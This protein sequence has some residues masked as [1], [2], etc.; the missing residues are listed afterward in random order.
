MMNRLRRV[1]WATALVSVA[2]GLMLSMQFKVQRQVALADLAAVQRT[3]ELV[4]QLAEAEKHRDELAA[5]VELLRQQ[6]LIS[7]KT[8]NEFQALA[9]QLEQAQLQAGLLPLVGPGVT[10]TMAD[11][12][13]PVTPGENP[14]NFIIHDEDVLRVI[15]ELRAAGAEAIAINGQRVTGRT[16]IR[17]TGPVV[18]ING[19]RTAPP[20]T[21][22]AIGNP[23][24]LERAIMMKGG[25]AESLKFWG[26]QVT[27]KKETSVRVPAYTA[28][29]RLEYAQPA[30]EVEEVAP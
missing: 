1:P 4:A 11:S 3:E 28:R 27:V 26:I 6:Q 7:V 18:T 22:V 5:E 14:N 13:L 20:L 29:L 17:C 19:V 9:E 15:N 10:V 25:V 24:E 21:I 23:D 2:L 30:L 12:S 8:Q 16:E